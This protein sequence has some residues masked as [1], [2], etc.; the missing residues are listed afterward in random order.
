[1]IELHPKL[2]DR[3]RV[4]G[5]TFRLDEFS[6]Y[7]L[8]VARGREVRDDYGDMWPEDAVQDAASQLADRLMDLGFEATWDVS[9]KGFVEVSIFD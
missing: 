1:M 3:Y 2:D 8:W 5:F 6:D 9:E 4:G 7:P